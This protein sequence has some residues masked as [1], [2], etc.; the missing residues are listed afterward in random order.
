MTSQRTSRRF[1]HTWAVWGALVGAC[2]PLPFLGPELIRRVLHVVHDGRG[3]TSRW[4]EP[5]SY[6]VVLGLPLSVIGYAVGRAFGR[7]D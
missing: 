5:L 3:E 4:G 2:A 1:S 7:R 6:S